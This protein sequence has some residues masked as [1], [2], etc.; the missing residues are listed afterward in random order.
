MN[1]LVLGLSQIEK[2]QRSLVGGKAAAI[3]KMYFNSL[4]VP[5]TLCITTEAFEKYIKTTGLSDKII[6]EYYRKEFDDMRWEE[7]WDL[8]LRIKNM[9]LNTPIPAEIHSELEF[10]IESFFD[11][12]AVVVRSSSIE[13]DSAKYSFAGIHES[14]VNIKGVDSIL[15][16]IKLVWASL[17]SDSAIL[18]RKEIGLDV[19][20]SKMAV[21]L[22][23][24]VNGERSGVAFSRSP[25]SD[26]NMMIESVYGLNQGL[27]D[28]TVE[29]DRWILRRK[30]GQIISFTPAVRDKILIPDKTGI[31]VSSLS[32]KRKNKPPLTENQVHGVYV[33]CSN[34]ERVFDSA[35]DTEWSYLKRTLYCLQSRPITTNTFADEDRQRQWYLS[36]K[37]SLENLKELRFEIETK[38]I[39]QME[40]AAFAMENT[41]V[42]SLNDND[43]SDELSERKNAFDKWRDIYWDKF[44]PFAHGVRLFGEV[45]NRNMSPEDPYEFTQLLTNTKMKSLERNRML[46]KMAVF[47]KSV[48]ISGVNSKTAKKRFERMLDDFLVQFGDCMWGLDKINNKK[49]IIEL[50]KQMAAGYKKNIESPKNT[51]KLLKA[52]IDSFDEDDKSYAYEILD[53]ARTSY[54]LRDDDNIYLGKIEGQ[55]NAAFEESRKRLG[56]RTE[57]QQQ[58]LNIE[59]A[60]IALKDP[61]YRPPAKKDSKPDIRNFTVRSRQLTGQASSQGLAKGRA[62]IIRCREDVFKFKTGEILVCDAIDPNMTF[63]VPMAAGIVERRGGMLIH[64]AIIAREY[65]LPCITGVPNAVDLIENGQEITVDGY[66]GI[67]TLKKGR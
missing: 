60:I 45:Y 37:R 12:K 8:S 18:Y 63:I 20:S 62:R 44:I 9:F 10:E 17:F 1:F 21:V 14:Y 22:Q 64:G 3:S 36:L 40:N 23:E 4:K 7:I 53:L 27:V 25:D 46:K 39:P 51:K 61:S 19:N 32:C 57:I 33:M 49:A 29:P 50:I 52:F 48:L 28:G 34:A 5:K 59:E 13:E 42:Y 65:G 55:M 41:D 31:S 15:K 58:N 24:F 16:H 11:N 54:Q 66:L 43:L 38:L 67:V 30:D 26:A 2:A 6:M 35:Q 56:E 47:Y